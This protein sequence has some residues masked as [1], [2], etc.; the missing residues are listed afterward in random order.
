M[1]IIRSIRSC[2]NAGELA[3]ELFGFVG[4][5]KLQAGLAL[6]RNFVV[7]PQG[8]VQ[9]RAGF[10]FVA[11]VKDVSKRTRL[12]PFAF[13]H[14]QTFA[15]ELGAGYFRFHSDGGTLTAVGS[16]QL[17]ANNEFAAS[18]AGWS[19]LSGSGA[20]IAWDSGNGG[21]LKL[22][23]VSGTVHAIACQAIATVP[24]QV[25][26]VAAATLDGGGYSPFIWVGSTAGG[27][28]LSFTTSQASFIPAR[29]LNNGFGWLLFT[30]TGTISYVS[31]VSSR[32]AGVTHVQ[33][34][35]CCALNEAVMPWSDTVGSG[36]SYAYAAGDLASDAAGNVFYA[37]QT[38]PAG[39]LLSN[40]S[41]WQPMVGPYEVANPYAEGDLFDVHFVQSGDVLSLVHP[42]YAP[43]E[44]R[45]YGDYRWVLADIAF[46]SSLSAPVIGS[47]V[48]SGSG[49]SPVNQAYA[50]V[51]TGLDAYGLEESLASAAVSAV[52]DLSV[53]GYAVSVS[54]SVPMT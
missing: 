46:V 48:V 39:T 52:T 47:A 41:Y 16:A 7:L 51:V 44:L 1:P 29:W 53:S 49:G 45:R 26:M 36:N 2:F 17:L 37:L 21:Q 32:F 8:P 50:Y 9:N 12:I 6:C 11:K 5:E 19:D 54:W 4:L 18:I 38:V 3:A 43:M 34:V 27:S 25:Y 42:G 22:T 10:G 14:A 30:A 28:D 31:L 20:A 35:V 33:G 23:G 40:T 15:V 24:G 13:N